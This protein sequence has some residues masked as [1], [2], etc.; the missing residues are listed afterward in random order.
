VDTYGEYGVCD[1]DG[2]GTDDLF[3]A[4]GASW[5]FSSAGRMHWVYLNAGQERLHQ[6]GLGDFDGDGRCDVFA[7]NGSQWK[8]SRGGSSPWTPLP[9]TYTASF[10][11]L[12]F[13][14]FN[15]DGTTDVF[16]R[17]PDGQ[18]SAISPGIYDWTA[19]QSS[20]FPLSD[21]RFGHF[22]N[23]RVTDVIAVEGGRWAVSYGGA[24]TWDPLKS[25]LADRLEALR[26]ADIDADGLDDILR[27]TASRDGLT[28]SWEISRGGAT[29]WQPLAHLA[30]ADTPQAREF[31]PANHVRWFL[32]RFNRGPDWAGY[33]VL[34][35]DHERMG[36]LYS[37]GRAGF[38]PH[39]LHA[40]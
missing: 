20:S 36:H 27:Y 37:T 13:G 23:D 38:A 6:V 10:E 39:N 33:D 29:R 12:R 32:G 1:F 31:H 3:L 7:V 16:H 35:L 18:W 34:A 26:I 24:T 21:L 15:G 30:W 40:F 17:A 22:N 9:G 14:D 19:L 5:W 25:G 2:D 8:I 11:Q 4:T 28:G